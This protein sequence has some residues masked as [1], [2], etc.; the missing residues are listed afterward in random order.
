MI[1]NKEK[2]DESNKIIE[3]AYLN[4]KFY[5][6]KYKGV[7][8]LEYSSIPY[9]TQKDIAEN[10]IDMRASNHIFRTSIS[11]GTTGKAKVMYRTVDDVDISIKMQ[12]K[13]MEWCKVDKSDTVGVAQP[14]GLCAYGDLTMGACKKMNIMCVP[15]GNI[16]NKFVLKYIKDF[17]IT[18]LDISPSKLSDLIDMV[19]LNKEKIRIK[20]A[21][22]AGEPIPEFLEKRAEQLLGC[23]IYNQY[24]TEELDGLAGADKPG[25]SMKLLDLKYIFELRNIQIISKKIIGELVVTSLY[26]KGTPIIKYATGDLCSYDEIT[27]KIRILGR[28]AENYILYDSVKI[29]P[30]HVENFFLDN[31]YPITSWECE[32]QRKEKFSVLIIKIKDI[33]SEGLDLKKMVEEFEMMNSEINDLVKTNKLIINFVKVNEMSK[34][35]SRKKRHFF[36]L[37]CENDGN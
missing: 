30:F 37:G 11:S 18:V 22:V 12:S 7:K 17:G 1:L 32:L 31:N 9:I 25:V 21:M 28:K 23:Q 6:N 19:E 5:S 26:H 29:Y 24:G 34:G 4:S 16:D 27:H 35:F 33:Q 3:Y 14:F 10:S 36:S 13:L 15:M 2:Y 8:T 20:K